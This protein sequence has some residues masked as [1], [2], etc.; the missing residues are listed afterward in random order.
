MSV[1]LSHEQSPED[2]MA[3]MEAISNVSNVDRCR[4]F[5]YGKKKREQKIKEDCPR[6]TQLQ[7]K[8]KALRVKEG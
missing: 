6:N 7:K 5:T 8:A 4:L 2:T 1:S 3:K